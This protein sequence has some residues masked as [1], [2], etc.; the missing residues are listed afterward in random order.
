MEVGNK[1]FHEVVHLLGC[2]A[3]QRRFQSRFASK[4]SFFRPRALPDISDMHTV[5]LPV[6]PAI[7]HRMHARQ[8]TAQRYPAA[9]PEPYRPVLLSDFFNSLVFLSD[10]RIEV[11]HRVGRSRALEASWY[12]ASKAIRSALT[13]PPNLR[14]LIAASAW[15]TIATCKLCSDTFSVRTLR[16]SGQ[17][18]MSFRRG[19]GQKMALFHSDLTY[20]DIIRSLW[21]DNTAGCNLRQ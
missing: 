6:S 11:F 13:L 18:L 7:F 16:I 9:L 12:I 2:G 10:L 15:A 1:Y 3:L 14:F 5:H 4:N 17:R 20:D 19:D 21:R 8:L